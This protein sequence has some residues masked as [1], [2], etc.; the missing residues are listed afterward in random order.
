[1]AHLWT[2]HIATVFDDGRVVVR[3]VFATAPANDKDRLAAG[4]HALLQPQ[5]LPGEIAWK[6]TPQVGDRVVAS[7]DSTYEH[8]PRHS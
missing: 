4:T 3:G 6:Q 1:M 8:F 2:G 7:D 5:F